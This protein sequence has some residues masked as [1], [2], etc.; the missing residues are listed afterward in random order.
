[1]KIIYTDYLH[2]SKDNNY[3]KLGEIEMEQNFILE[4][5][6]QEKFVYTNYEVEVTM[7]LDTD[8]GNAKIV[9]VDGRKVADATGEEEA[10]QA[11]ERRNS[12]KESGG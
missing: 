10:I 8:T 4:E 1:M 12:D 5:A 11:L 7:E 2:N 9:A 6:Q 3:E